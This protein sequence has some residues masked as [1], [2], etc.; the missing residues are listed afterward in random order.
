MEYG[1]LHDLLRNETMYLSGEIIL[2]ITRDIGQ[3]LRFLHSS[4]PVILHGDLKAKNI[5]ID[6]RF[7][8]KICDFGLSL[9]QSGGITGTPYWLA[10]EYLRGETS[11]NA[12]CD[13]YSIGIILFEIYSRQNPYEGEDFR[14]VLRKVCNRTINKRPDIPNTCPPKMA[15]LMKKCWNKDPFIRPLAKVLDANLLEMNMQDAEPLTEEQQSVQR[16]ERATGDMLY[17]LFPKHI[18]DALKAGQKV[19]PENHELVTVV[20]SDIVHFTD[21][22]REISPLKVSEMLDRLYLAFDKVSSNKRRLVFWQN[23]VCLSIL[24]FALSLFRRSPVSTKF[25]RYDFDCKPD[26]RTGAV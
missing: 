1:S 22:S 17:Q 18:A 13:I 11:Y 21:I 20:F 12:S 15:D 3:G 6:A 8:A 25:L 7:R 16:K 19:E 10:P 23:R 24:H 26:T 9:K 4:K 5:L 2:Q 14:D